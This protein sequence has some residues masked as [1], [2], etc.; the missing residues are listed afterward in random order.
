MRNPVRELQLVVGK[1][2]LLLTFAYL[3]TLLAAMIG[4]ATGNTLPILGYA[5]LLL[6]GVA[7]YISARDAIKLHRA[8]DPEQAKTLLRTC[9]L[10]GVIGLALLI[11]TGVILNSMGD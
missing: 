5:F 10:Y 8:D 3:L 9:A 1:L 11:A 4:V 6:P 7:F 2:A